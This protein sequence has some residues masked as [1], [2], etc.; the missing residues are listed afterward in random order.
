MKKWQIIVLIPLLFTS[1]FGCK[2]GTISEPYYYY[3]MATATQSGFNPLFKLD[4]SSLVRPI[5]D[6]PADSFIM[7]QRYFLFFANADTTGM[8]PA[9][10]P[11]ML[12]YY[13]K[14]S[15]YNMEVLHPDSL[16]GPD[17]KPILNV[18]YV[19][20]SGRYINI[21][22]ETFRNVSDNPQYRLV[23]ILGEEHNELTDLQPEFVFEL[24]QQTELVHSSMRL[25]HYVSFDV[26][27]L[28]SEYTHATKIKIKL[29]YKTSGGGFAIYEYS[30][31]PNVTL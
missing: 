6:M 31:K 29:K 26:G 30:Y 3:S 19:W 10:K 28:G 4:D 11:I 8:S 1:F 21:V 24:R 2:E 13:R 27:N 15:M 5:N 12:E 17:P 25:A 14:A 9:Y 22:F 7:G 18:Q 16:I 23:R 20:I